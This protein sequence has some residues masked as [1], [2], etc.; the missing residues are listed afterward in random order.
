M[1]DGGI[2]ALVNGAGETSVS[3]QFTPFMTSIAPSRIVHLIH[4][5]CDLYYSLTS[6]GNYQPSE[7]PVPYAEC[8]N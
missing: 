5:A 3:M 2:P 8:G 1:Y 4:V 7:L 6:L